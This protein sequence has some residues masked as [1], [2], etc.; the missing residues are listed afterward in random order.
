[1]S[2][3]STVDRRGLTQ[4][5][6]HDDWVRRQAI[7]LPQPTLL[8]PTIPDRINRLNPQERAELGQLIRS[9]KLRK[10]VRHTLAR[11]FWD[12]EQRRQ[13]ADAEVRAARRFESHCAVYDRAE[14]FFIKG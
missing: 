2:F 6:E 8:A 9:L 12:G 14:A 4:Q 5:R 1:M 7:E 13:Q 10:I 11:A 3:K